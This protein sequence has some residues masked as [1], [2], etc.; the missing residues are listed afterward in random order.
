MLPT[1]LACRQQGGQSMRSLIGLVLVAGVLSAG[2]GGTGAKELTLGRWC[3]RAPG[4]GATT[5]AIV[6]LD[7][8]SVSAQLRYG[9]G[10]T[11]QQALDEKGHGI[12]AVRES[13]SSDYYRLVLSTG[14]LQLV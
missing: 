10:S 6:A 3:Y 13:P 11:N 2:M 12:Y 7:D 5:I 4:S 9:D 8:G 14:N 1:P